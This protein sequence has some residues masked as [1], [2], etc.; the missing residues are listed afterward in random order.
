MARTYR[1]ARTARQVRTDRYY[2]MR[3]RQVRADPTNIDVRPRELSYHSTIYETHAR[4]LLDKQYVTYHV[5]RRSG[6]QPPLDLILAKREARAFS[7][8]G[9][10]RTFSR[11]W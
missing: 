1:R 8:S 4:P 2:K 6:S 10:R 3:R 7:G 9:Q 5:S 11:P